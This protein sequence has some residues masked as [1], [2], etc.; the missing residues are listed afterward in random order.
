M[1]VTQA[2]VNVTHAKPG[3]KF[4]F[5]YRY[6]QSSAIDHAPSTRSRGHGQLPRRLPQWRENL[7]PAWPSEFGVCVSEK[8][9]KRRQERADRS[10]LYIT[11]I[12]AVRSSQ[13]GAD[14]S[15]ANRATKEA[16]RRK[17]RGVRSDLFLPIF[18]SS[19]F[20][21]PEKRRWGTEMF[22]NYKR[23]WGLVPGP[24]ITINQKE[25]I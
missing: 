14:R 2:S 17:K 10:H 7:P 6:L 4:L 5:D 20:D 24:S 9:S 11:T 1:S 22:E 15:H 21:D 3:A 8:E 25:V 19:L 18:E 13:E 12:G 23:S 16:V